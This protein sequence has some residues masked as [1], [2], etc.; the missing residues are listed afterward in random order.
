[1]ISSPPPQPAAHASLLE[2][3]PVPFILLLTA[4][5]P[6]TSKPNLPAS[7]TLG[8]HAWLGRLRSSC[9]VQMGG[10]DAMA[11]LG[12]RKK[13]HSRGSGNNNPCPQE[14]RRR[15]AN[16]PTSSVGIVSFIHP[17]PSHAF[18]TSTWLLKPLQT[19]D[20][21]LA[22]VA[23]VLSDGDRRRCEWFDAMV[24][25]GCSHLVGCTGQGT[26]FTSPWEGR[27]VEA[28]FF[29]FEML[30]SRKTTQ[31]SA[32]G[33]VILAMERGM[34]EVAA[35]ILCPLKWQ[36]RWRIT[37]TSCERWGDTGS[38]LELATVSITSL[39]GCNK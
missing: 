21:H 35:A 32:R 1:M 11:G 24:G 37:H 31:T 34:E 5:T 2:T 23:F 19:S 20:V 27:R 12:H 28:A 38:S 26:H 8:L 17:R 29:I 16:T 6:L 36:R 18:P 25:R 15:K 9:H 7:V 3:I 39:I 13:T 4:A 14:G 30:P 22:R 10:L 33:G